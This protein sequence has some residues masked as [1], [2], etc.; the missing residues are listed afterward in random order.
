[1]GIGDMLQAQADHEDAARYRN[2]NRYALSIVK[3]LAKR[4][5]AVP[6]WQPLDDLMGKLTQ[7]DNMTAKLR[8]G[9]G[10]SGE[11]AK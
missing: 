9:Y 10:N 4:F 2:C 8:E 1:M 7:I 6:T 3:S 11:A 5:P